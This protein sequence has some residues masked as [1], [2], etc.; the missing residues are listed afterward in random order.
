[1]NILLTVNKYKY[2]Q[3][4][5]YLE[6]EKESIEKDCEDEKA[7]KKTNEMARCYMLASVQHAFD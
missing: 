7:W 4:D 6:I 1:M 3:S 2:V 5:S